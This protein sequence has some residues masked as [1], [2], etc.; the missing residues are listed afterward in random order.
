[1]MELLIENIKQSK[2]K[3]FK[4]DHRRISIIPKAIEELTC[5]EL[6]EITN[7]DINKVEALPPNLK[8]LDLSKN[9]NLEELDISKYPIERLVLNDCKKLNKLLMSDTVKTLEATGTKLNIIPHFSNTLTSINLYDAYINKLNVPNEEVVEIINGKEEKKII[10]INM[11]PKNI[12]SVSI[13]RNVLKELGDLNFDVLSYLNI[14]NNSIKKIGKLCNS[15]KRLEI[16]NIEISEITFDFPKNLL[17]LDISHNRLKEINNLPDTLEILE[18]E[19]NKLEKVPKLGSN[20]SRLILRHNN[21]TIFPEEIPKSLTTIDISNNEIKTIPK[22]I[23]EFPNKQCCVF[24]TIEK[25]PQGEE[26]LLH[27]L[28]MTR[29]RHIELSSSFFMNQH[30]EE[31]IH[32]PEDEI[33]TPVNIVLD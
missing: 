18:A 31:H 24:D 29:E 14:S 10:N 27:L 33:E 7:C 11:L 25:K 5:V 23:L 4:I 9:D 3:E 12:R 21:L 16:C 6:L 28:N 8:T 15:I 1:M 22:C 13:S 32:K 19:H 30:Q 2:S 17:F 26:Q 20:L